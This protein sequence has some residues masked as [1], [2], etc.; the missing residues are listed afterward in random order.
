[1]QV[2]VLVAGKLLIGF[3]ALIFVINISG[4]RTDSCRK[5]SFIDRKGCGMGK[6][7]SGRAGIRLHKRGLPGRVSERQSALLS[8]ETV[9]RGF[10]R[11]LF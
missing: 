2:F 9:N 8:G 10:T 6:E 11:P 3:L 5:T 7:R 1:M 4:L